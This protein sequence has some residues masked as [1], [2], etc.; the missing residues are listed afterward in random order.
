MTDTSQKATCQ[1]AAILAHLQQHG[2]ISSA[3]SRRLF[4]C[5][6]LRSRI[7]NLRR[8]GVEI[9]TGCGSSKAGS[10]IA[11]RT[12]CIICA[13]LKKKLLKKAWCFRN[14]VIFVTAKRRRRLDNRCKEQEH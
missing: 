5:E 7:A 8:E 2:S 6:A 14:R 4:G 11:G 10:G 9:E 12:Q 1:K 13:A 3:E